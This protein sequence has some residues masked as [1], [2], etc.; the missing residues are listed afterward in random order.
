MWAAVFSAA[1]PSTTLTHLSLPYSIQPWLA[2]MLCQC[3]PALAELTVTDVSIYAGRNGDAVPKVCP[4]RTLVLSHTQ[5]SHEP[6]P[7]WL[8]L[9]AEGKLVIDVSSIPRVLLRLNEM[10]S[11][12]DEMLPRIALLTYRSSK[13]VY[14]YICACSTCRPRACSEA[15]AWCIYRRAYLCVRR[16]LTN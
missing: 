10:V 8:P 9:P 4:W 6:F 1:R 14:I 16:T 5:D 3:L 2:T 11:R 7:A 13:F 15:G 12:V